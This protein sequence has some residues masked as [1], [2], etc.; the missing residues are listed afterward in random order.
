[1]DGGGGCTE[2]AKTNADKGK[3][4]E[5]NADSLEAT[6]ALTE[7]PSSVKSWFVTGWEINTFQIFL[8]HISRL[9]SAVHPD[10]NLIDSK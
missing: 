10:M 3:G 4:K 9:L 5:A 7:A 6:T 2:N 1:M 8:G